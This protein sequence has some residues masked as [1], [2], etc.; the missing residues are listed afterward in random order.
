MALDVKHPQ[1]AGYRAY[2]FGLPATTLEVH[3]WNLRHGLNAG[4]PRRVTLGLDMLMFNSCTIQTG[5]DGFRA[6]RRRLNFA[7]TLD[8][9]WGEQWLRDHAGMLMT[10]QSTGRFGFACR[11]SRRSQRLASAHPRRPTTW[12]R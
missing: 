3:L 6:Y 8:W 12:S 5:T 7:D 10:N 4:S 2:N 9:R 1:W 11:R